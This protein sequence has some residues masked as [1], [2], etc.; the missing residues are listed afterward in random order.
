MGT[1][2]VDWDVLSDPEAPPSVALDLVDVHGLLL[3]GVDPCRA[4]VA[5]D[6]FDGVD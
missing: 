5:R 6:V 4:S 1:A 3:S 2:L